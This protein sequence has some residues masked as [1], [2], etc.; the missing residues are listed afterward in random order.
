MT[1]DKT[2]QTRINAGLCKDCGNPRGE[3]GTSIHCRPCAS[4]AAKR[5]TARVA[6]IRKERLRAGLCFGCGAERDAETVYCSKC[7]EKHKE[8]YPARYDIK[9]SQSRRRRNENAGMCR[10][11]GKERYYSSSYCSHHFIANIARPY[12]IPTSM[13]NDLLRK[14]E[15]SNFACFYTGK[16]LVPGVNACI[17]HLYSRSQHPEKMSDLD[18]LVWCDKWVNRMKGHMSYQDFISLC[19][20][21]V[22]GAITQE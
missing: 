3:N 10:E 19:Q 8:K 15:Q 1:Y 14:L 4:H 5:A 6:R 20:T 7:K 11:C 22:E 12:K 9:H 17:D 18:N 2:Q 16:E 13:W 21:I